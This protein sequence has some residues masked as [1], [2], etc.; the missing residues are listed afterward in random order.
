MSLTSKKMYQYTDLAINLVLAKQALQQVR[1]R[2][3]YADEYTPEF[4]KDII[5]MINNLEDLCDC[6]KKK[7][8]NDIEGGE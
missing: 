6:I 8:K 3:K 1:F 7:I 2:Y 5:E 4:D